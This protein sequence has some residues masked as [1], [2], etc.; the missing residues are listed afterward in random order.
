MCALT[1]LAFARDLETD[2]GLVSLP[3][4]KGWIASDSAFKDK[5]AI[6]QPTETMEGTT[7]ILF[8]A[9]EPH[10]SSGKVQKRKGI[11]EF[12]AGTQTPGLIIGKSFYADYYSTCFVRSGHRVCAMLTISERK[13]KDYIKRTIDEFISIVKSLCD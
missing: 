5:F 4:P 7:T 8:S 12:R 2:G 10:T 9:F 1:S 3:V 13:D 6:R 11:R